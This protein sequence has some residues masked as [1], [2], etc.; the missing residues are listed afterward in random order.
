MSG[1]EENKVIIV[2]WF[3]DFWRRTCDMRNALRK[4][5]KLDADLSQNGANAP[6]RMTA[7][8]VIPHAA[9]VHHSSPI[10]ASGVSLDSSSPPSKS[11]MSMDGK[12]AQAAGQ[13]L[14]LGLPKTHR[15]EDFSDA[16]FS[17]II[18]LLVLEIHR[19]SVAP[20]RL[21]EGLL[22]EWSSYLAYVLAFIYVG[23]IWLNHHYMF[24]RLCKVDLTLNWINLGIIGTAALI[25]FPTGVLA[26]AF[27][28]GDL[29]DC[30]EISVS[31]SGEKLVV[32]I[33]ME[34]ISL[35]PQLRHLLIGNLD[36][37]R[38][39]IGIELA[40]HGETGLRR[41][42]SDQINDDLVTDQRRAPPVLADEREQAVFDLI[43]LAGARRKMADRNLQA[44]FVC[45][46]L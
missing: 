41:G 45:E 22:M 38:I 20:G 44:R 1:L 37:C 34:G 35:E 32:P 27:R 16:A 29:R 7:E 23:V 21:E 10:A 40:F 17:I 9:E 2:R 36:P 14:M 4:G 19:P 15:V 39:G 33:A 18:T 12:V 3:K 42:G 11:V 25:P 8:R 28:D 46:L 6:R 26:S 24:E 31:T 43:P 13:E 5:S 30:Q